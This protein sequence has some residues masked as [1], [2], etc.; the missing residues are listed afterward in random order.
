MRLK[1]KVA[2][3]TGGARGLGRATALAFAKEGAAVA[4]CDMPTD[5]SGLGSEIE[6]T[7]ARYAYFPCD[8]TKSDQ[9]SE[10]VNAQSSV[11]S[12]F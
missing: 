8:V 4:V 2:F 7:G 12:T 6:K 10:V 5:D 1:N 9:V 3:V 11:Q